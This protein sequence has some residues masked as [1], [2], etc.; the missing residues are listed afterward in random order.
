MKIDPHVFRAKFP[1]RCSLQRCKSRCCSGGV[2]ADVEERDVILRNADRFLPYVRPEAKDPSLWFGETV[3]DPDCPSGTAVETNVAGDYC[4]FFHPDHGCSLQ[5]AAVDLGRH[6]WEWKPRFCVMFPLVVSEGV[7]T[8]DEDME[9]V[10]CMENENRTHPIISAV[11]REVNYLFPEEVARH[12][13]T[14]GNGAKKISV[15]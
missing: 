10:W 6:E 3:A 7:L 11:E 8:V 13:L 14:N 9:E 12:L 1:H 15:A 2:W 4:V 5:K